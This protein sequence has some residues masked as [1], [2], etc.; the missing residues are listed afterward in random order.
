MMMGSPNKLKRKN[1]KVQILLLEQ[2][3]R[4]KKMYKERFTSKNNLNLNPRIIL[5]TFDLKQLIKS[6]YY[7]FDIASNH[8]GGFSQKKIQIRTA[9]INRNGLFS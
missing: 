5:P 7:N 4:K 9:Q 3:P 1:L 2:Y 8:A 6:T